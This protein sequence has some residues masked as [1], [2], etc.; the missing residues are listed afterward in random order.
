MNKSST[1]TIN[2]LHSLLCTLI[3][4]GYGRRS[5][6]IDKSS[7]QDAREGDGVVILN[8][9]SADIEMVPQA[10]EDGGTAFNKNGSE[11][12]QMCLV[13]CGHAKEGK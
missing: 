11:K 10:D 3:T 13:I 1:M 7:F 5:V 4:S 2:S 6:C 9:A 8:V 12:I